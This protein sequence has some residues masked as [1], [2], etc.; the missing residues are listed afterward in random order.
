M[1][2]RFF[3][4]PIHDGDEA[5]AELNR[6]LAEARVL[7]IDRQFVTDG[8]NSAWAICVTLHEGGE[9]PA[10][11]GRRV[12]KIDYKEL[13]SP[14]DFALFAR[15]RELRKQLAEREGV[16]PY[17]VFTNEQLASIVQGRVMSATGLKA[18]DGIGEAR[19]EKYAAPVLAIMTA[20]NG[21]GETIEA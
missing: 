3:T 16:P 1:R 11:A 10:A 5:A 4:I 14:D 7:A 8:A 6:C 18:I 2:Y 20:A 9:R 15:L 17:A 21:S 13:L 19:V 12:G